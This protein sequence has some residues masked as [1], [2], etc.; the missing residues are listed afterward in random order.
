M[1][2]A[3]NSVLPESTFFSDGAFYQVMAEGRMEAIKN[4]ELWPKQEDFPALPQH[5]DLETSNQ[6]SP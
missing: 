1:S 3:T 6:D 5:H 2:N 4:R